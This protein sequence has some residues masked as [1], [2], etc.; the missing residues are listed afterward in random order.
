MP[1]CEF[2]HINANTRPQQASGNS[3]QVESRSRLSCQ[4][5]WNYRYTF[6]HGFPGYVS[7]RLTH[8]QEQAG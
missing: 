7:T 3:K 6:A 8:C 2:N 5:P 4:S 1:N